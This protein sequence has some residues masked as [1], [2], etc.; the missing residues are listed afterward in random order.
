MVKSFE[1]PTNR[2][3]KHASIISSQKHNTI[4]RQEK[5]KAIKGAKHDL[6]QYLMLCK[7]LHCLWTL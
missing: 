2:C 6:V 4:L 1:I 5:K 3:N 7:V